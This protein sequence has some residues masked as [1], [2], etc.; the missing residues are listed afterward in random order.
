MHHM[1]CFNVIFSSDFSEIFSNEIKYAFL[2][3]SIKLQRYNDVRWN[4]L[5]IT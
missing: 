4:I 3:I 1:S 2:F 5:N